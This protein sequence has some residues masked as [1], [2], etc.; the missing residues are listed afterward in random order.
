MYFLFFV[1]YSESVTEEKHVEN[2]TKAKS[3]L[4]LWLV[5]NR[6][7]SSMQVLSYQKSGERIKP[8]LS[9]IKSPEGKKQ[10]SDVVEW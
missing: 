10:S 4:V 9:Q 6:F 1:L 3:L 5:G 2:S 8:N 7:F